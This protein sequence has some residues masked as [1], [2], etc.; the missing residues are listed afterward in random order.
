[1]IHG[2]EEFMVWAVYM[3]NY[4]NFEHFLDYF[5]FFSYYV[6]TSIYSMHTDTPGDIIRDMD[7]KC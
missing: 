1:L 6:G 2:G 3:W 7:S 4:D 5:P